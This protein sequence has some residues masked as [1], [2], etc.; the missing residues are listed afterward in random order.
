MNSSCKTP[1]SVPIMLEK[2]EFNCLQTI[3]LVVS[4][5]L[6]SIECFPKRSLY[7]T[8]YLRGLCLDPYCS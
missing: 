2:K 5:M 7:N 4:D 8:A 3:V 6:I 1:S